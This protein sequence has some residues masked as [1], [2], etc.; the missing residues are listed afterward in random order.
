MKFRWN[1][2]GTYQQVIPRYVSTDKFGKDEREFLNEHFSSDSEM[3]NAIFGKGY[4]WPFD[5]QGIFTSEGRGP[6]VIDIAVFLER[7]KGRRVFLDYTHNPVCAG[8]SFNFG[9]L[10]PE[11]TEYL[12]KSGALLATPIERLAAM[13][14]KAITLFG[15]HGIDLSREMLEIDVCAQHNNGGFEVNTDWESPT[16]A[17]FFPVGECAGTFGIRRPGG[18]ALNSTQVGSLRA[19]LKIASS[20]RCK[21]EPAGLSGNIKKEINDVEENLDSLVGGNMKL[22]DIM[23]LRSEYGKKMSACAAYLRSYNSVVKLIREVGGELE[24]FDNT[25]S[26]SDPALLSE[27]AINRDVLLTQYIY[28]CAIRDYIDDGGLSRGSYLITDLPAKA[29]LAG[30]LTDVEADE[31]HFSLIQRVLY[32][33]GK[34]AS[35]FVPVRPIPATDDWFEKLLSKSDS[36]DKD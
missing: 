29:I 19:A 16:C 13:N 6:S 21:R 33:D 23:F 15:E 11:G 34:V 27:V 22:P 1:L 31:K 3:I 4:H 14:E 20:F 5:P 18:T 24:A 35:E 8:A 9:M 26:V 12:K 32:K 30:E 7:L 28:L 17:H 2:S 36:E 25:Y 10:K